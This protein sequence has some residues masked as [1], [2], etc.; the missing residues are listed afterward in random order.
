MSEEIQTSLAQKFSLPKEWPS[1]KE[2]WQSNYA[3]IVLEFEL[4][5]H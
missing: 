1:E 4:Y 5:L 2:L 3:K